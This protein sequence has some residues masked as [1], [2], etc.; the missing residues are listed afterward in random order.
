MHVFLQKWFLQI[1]FISSN[2]PCFLLS[3]YALRLFFFNFCQNIHLSQ[4]SQTVSVQG[5][6]SLI[7]AAQTLK[8]FLRFSTVCLL[9]WLVCVWVFLILPYTWLLLSALI[10]FRILLLS[11]LGT[12]DVLFN[13]SIR[14][15]LPQA[16]V[17]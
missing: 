3:L 17:D 6:P 16:S 10:S 4:S 11:I 5:K 2:R 7:V 1:C 9:P 15:L 12:S 13:F 14:N 8:V